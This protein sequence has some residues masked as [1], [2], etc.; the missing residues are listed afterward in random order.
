L[1]IK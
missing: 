1:S